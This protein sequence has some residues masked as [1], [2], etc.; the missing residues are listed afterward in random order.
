MSIG[1]ILLAQSTII[2]EKLTQTL[3]WVFSKPL[4]PAGFIL[5]KFAAYAVMIGVIV[6]GAPSIAAYIGSMIIGLPVKISFFNY[7]A[8]VWMLYL[9]FLFNLAIVILLGVLFNR[10]GAVTALSLLIFF[11]GSSLQSYPLF[12]QIEPYTVWAL[13]HNA[14]ETMAGNFQSTTWLA[15]ISAVASIS[16]LLIVS[17]WWIKRS[18]F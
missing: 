6:L 10:T 4:S 11:S 17:T 3:L 7:L 1:T 16:L 8:A 12:K 18:E 9:L 5:G 13:Q 2:E 14:Y 15:M